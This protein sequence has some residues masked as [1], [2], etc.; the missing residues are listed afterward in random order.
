[1]AP[2]THRPLE[3]RRGPCPSELAVRGSGLTHRIAERSIADQGDAGVVDD[4]VQPAIGH[5][6]HMVGDPC[7][8]V[9][10][11]GPQLRCVDR[12]VEGDL[13]DARFQAGDEVDE[14]V[15]GAD[16]RAA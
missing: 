6:Q 12:R 3:R 15:V 8:P 1:M 5:Q 11:D 10:G 9:G 13:G 4:P 2:T 7:L 16:G 14:C